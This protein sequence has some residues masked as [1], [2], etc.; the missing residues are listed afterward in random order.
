MNTWKW[1]TWQGKPYLTCSL[2]EPFPHGFFTQ[3]FRP[4]TPRELVRV[5][6][7]E[8][9][10]YRTQQVHGNT[11]VRTCDLEP[12][13][14]QRTADLQPA[15]GILTHPE[16][17]SKESVWVCSADCTPV[18]IADLRRGCVSAIHAGWR[19]T[20][21]NIVPEAIAALREGGSRQEDLRVALGPAISGEVYQVSS[22]VAVQVGRSIVSVG[23][24]ASEE[25]VLQQ[26]S[27]LPESPVLPDS[28]PGKVRLDVRQAIRLQLDRLEIS[29]EQIAV[30]SE[31][32]YQQSDRFFSYRRTGEKKVQWSGIA[33]RNAT[34]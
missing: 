11:V 7:A 23:D 4:D 22:E 16:G 18:L 33:S 14:S 15:D 34:D 19:G 25:E 3:Q 27:E 8:A 31:C 26:V 21:A 12:L 10:A 9:T 32:T 29:P 13:S 28:Q 5:L 17:D 20:A 30:S 1:Q 24:E 6:D 2:L